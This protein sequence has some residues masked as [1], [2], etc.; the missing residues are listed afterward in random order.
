[1]SSFLRGSLPFRLAANSGALQETERRRNCKPGVARCSFSSYASGGT[2]D[3]YAMLGVSCGADASEI[4]SSYRKLALRYHPDV[5]PAGDREQCSRMFMR[6][7]EAYQVLCDPEQRA[8][9]DLAL[10]R[11]SG[12][13]QR[14]SSSS[15]SWR[16]Q[17]DAIRRR[18]PKS[19]SWA[20]TMRTNSR[21]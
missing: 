12:S 19:G 1:M 7:Q 4:K 18:R 13:F 11:G 6:V 9:Y 10:V 14:R 5:C 15:V 17:V 8:G 20:A 16:A 21:R 2:A 3:L